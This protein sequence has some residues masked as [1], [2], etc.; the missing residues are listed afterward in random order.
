MSVNIPLWGSKTRTSLL[1]YFVEQEFHL[2]VSVLPLAVREDVLLSY[3]WGL[4]AAHEMA[5]F[6]AKLYNDECSFFFYHVP[7]HSLAVSV[8]MYIEFSTN[9]FSPEKPNA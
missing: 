6:H 5:G 1:G 2:P 8:Y 4:F 7:N 3:T 9:A